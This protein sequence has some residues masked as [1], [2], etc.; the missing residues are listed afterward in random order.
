[1]SGKAL[2]DHFSALEDPRQS[3]KV[4]YPLPEMLL[5][6]LCGTL[7][8][9]ENFVEICRWGRE[10]LDFLRTMLPFERG[11]P[12]HDTLNDVLNALDPALF[13]ACFTAWVDSLRE[14]EPDIVAI[15]GKSSRRA[16]RGDAHPLH[17]V[18]AWASRQR[19]VLGQEAVGEKAN[20]IVAI[21]L[22]LERLQLTGAL[23]TIDAMGTQ[24]KIAETILGKG[25]DYLLP[26]KDNWPALAAD[27]RL[28]FEDPGSA[29]LDRCE[30]TEG[31][32]GRIETRRHTVCHGV[33]WLQ[34]ARRYPGEP[35]FPGLKAIAMVETEVERGGRPSLERRYYLSSIRLEAKHFARAVRAHWSIENRLHWVLDVVFHDDLMRLRTGHGP[36]NMAVIKHM[37]TNLLR[38]A[39]DK[40][41][42]ATRRKAAAWSQNYLKAIVMQTA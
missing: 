25:A 2:L 18:S 29:V 41:S 12:S 24:T 30:E 3:W 35:R 32:H 14:D 39:T 20:E 40:D 31:D 38:R 28:F 5:L 7:S 26:L 8:M 42:L 27:V 1:M 33:D 16:R 4:V 23:I 36:K 11:I 19:L 21:P 17:V 6:V 37:A 15:D 13:A 10:K 9:G 34:S 22:L